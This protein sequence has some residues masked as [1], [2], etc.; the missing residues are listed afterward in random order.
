MCSRDELIEVLMQMGAECPKSLAKKTTILM[1][2]AF[3]EDAYKR[4]TKQDITTTN[5]SKEARERGIL[6]VAHD[7]IEDFIK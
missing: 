4:R 2:G 5:K 7:D 3:V 1:Q 6:I